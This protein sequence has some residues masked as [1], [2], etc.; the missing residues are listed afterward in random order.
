MESWSVYVETFPQLNSFGK[1]RI[2][3]LLVLG[4]FSSYLGA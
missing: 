1:A 3:E 4:R 2:A